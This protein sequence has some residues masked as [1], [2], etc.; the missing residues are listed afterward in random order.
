MISCIETLLEHNFACR[1]SLLD[2]LDSLSYSELVSNQEVGRG[3][4]RNILVHL[5]ETEIYWMY[6][7]IGCN[8][9]QDRLDKTDF[10]DVDSIRRK[11]KETEVVTR[12]MFK[13][14]NEGTLQYV[15]SVRWGDRTVSFTVAKVFIH[16]ATHEIHHRGLIIGL[17]RKLGYKPPDV[18]MI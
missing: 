15:K 18:N 17:L 11:W 12:E 6:T 8:S 5:L 9:E 13:N 4:I 3:S 7:V 10:E 16:M 1:E 14:Q 2:A